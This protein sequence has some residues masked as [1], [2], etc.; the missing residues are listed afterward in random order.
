M[1]I[2]KEKKQIDNYIKKTS[3]VVSIEQPVLKLRKWAL[4]INHTNF[5]QDNLLKNIGKLQHI[6][7]SGDENPNRSRC[8]P[9]WAK[10]LFVSF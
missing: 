2:P 6:L 4:G 7:T 9:D 10:A 1:P 5:G 8:A 3:I